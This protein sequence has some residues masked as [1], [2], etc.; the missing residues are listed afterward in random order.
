MLGRLTTLLAILACGCGNPLAGHEYL[1][2]PLFSFKGQ[3]TSYLGSQDSQHEFRVSLFWS[4]SGQTRVAAED[5][6][7]QTSASVTIEFPST[8][9]IN[10]FYPPQAAHLVDGQPAYGLALI[11]V[12]EDRDENGRFTKDAQPSELVGGAR[13]HV[14]LYAPRALTSEQSPTGLPVPKG[15]TI[16]PIPLNCN[17]EFKP[18]T[19]DQDCGPELGASCKSDSECAG[20]ECLTSLGSFEVPGGYCSLEATEQGC[21]PAGGTVAQTGEAFW[22]KSCVSN[23]DC[24]RPG[25]ACIDL[26]YRLEY[27]C[28]ACWPYQATPPYNTYCSVYQNWYADPEC[29]EKLGRSCQQDSDCANV[30]DDGN[31]LHQLAGEDFSDGY[32]THADTSF[33]CMPQTAT[34]LIVYTSYWFK[35][36]ESRDDCRKDEDYTCDPV[37]RICLPQFPMELEIFP[38]FRVEK[39]VE[40][41][42]F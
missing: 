32:C 16:V 21:S 17:E 24:L 36:C 2:E 40:D 14:L 25:Y 27:S 34:Y 20:G 18:T 4:P 6:V 5:L 38:T 42:C 13:D 9:E 31:C 33:G 37:Y 1:G 39:H 7:E 15:F 29:G 3:V 28:K 12:Y 23:Q 19:G 30:F 41:L 10:V 35:Q 22:L 11:L 8:F 26:D